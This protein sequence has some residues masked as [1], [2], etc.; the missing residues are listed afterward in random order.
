MNEIQ[1]IRDRLVKAADLGKLD[2]VVRSSAFQFEDAL[3]GKEAIDEDAFAFVIAFL[4]D[5]RLMKSPSSAFFLGIINTEFDLFSP[6]QVKQLTEIVRSSKYL[7]GSPEAVLAAAA[8]L[9]ARRLPKALA[10]ELL[11]DAERAG[12]E[13]FQ[14]FG[15]DV[16]RKRGP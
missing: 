14:V 1:I 4:G 12:N 5:E 10:E 3:L 7:L 8:D 16:L 2:S 13:F 9:F 15:A 6:D 11:Q